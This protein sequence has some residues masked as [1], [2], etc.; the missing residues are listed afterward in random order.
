V[1]V[2]FAVFSLEAP[3]FDPKCSSYLRFL[4]PGWR[5]GWVVVHDR[6]EIFGT[7]VSFQGQPVP[8]YLA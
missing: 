5:M 7:E 1:S 2:L 6:E 3:V 4:V 8:D